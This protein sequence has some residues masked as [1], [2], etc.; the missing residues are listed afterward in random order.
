MFRKFIDDIGGNF[1]MITALLLV[2]M[3]GV[4][5]LGIDYSSA[6]LKKEDLQNAADS[7][8]LYAASSTETDEAKVKDLVT[9]TFKATAPAG[10]D[11][12]LTINAVTVDTDGRISLDATADLPVTMMKV[13]GQS[14][15]KVNIFAQSMRGSGDDVEIALVL[16]NTGSMAG[17][18]LTDLKAAA[19]DMV[20][21]FEND[22]RSKDKV[23][24]SVVPFSVYVNVGTKYRNESWLRDTQ[25]QSIKTCYDEQVQTGTKNC[26]Y[27]YRTY[28]PYDQ[29]CRYVTKTAYNDGAPYTYQQWVCDQGK[30]YSKKE[31]VC[32]P[33]YKTQ[34]KC[35]TTDYTWYG[36]V[37]SRDP[38]FDT[39][40]GSPSK[41]WPGIYNQTCGQTLLPL[42]NAYSSIYSKISSM[43]ASGQTYIQAGIMWGWNTLSQEAPFTEGAPYDSDVR[44]YMIVMTD[45]ENTR[46]NNWG[47]HTN[48]DTAAADKAMLET[49]TN[50]KARKISVFTIGVGVGNTTTGDNLAKCATDGSMAFS[51]DDSS[52]LREIFRKIGKEIMKPRLSM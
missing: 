26:R 32:D 52:A 15:I 43:S 18:K 22:K 29:N 10:F 7:A 42:T 4:V 27:E 14:A 16:D 8:V 2:P 12:S 48:Y 41:T 1:S 50:A 6:L 39:K 40:D 30:A 20:K 36:C 9:K 44:K 37:G 11:A 46:S 19:T 35:Y 45:G 24:F 51:M 31:Y 38:G 21:T 5:G 17:K 13:F 25:D 3:I 28:T 23:K 33:V 34:Q 49:C 47:Y